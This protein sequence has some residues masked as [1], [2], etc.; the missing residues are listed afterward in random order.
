MNRQQKK[1]Y[2]SASLICANFLDLEKDIRALEK[3]KID[4]LHIDVMD[5]IFVPRYGIFP[6][7]ITQVKKISSIPMDVHMMVVDP[8]KYL[9]T[10]LD[11]DSTR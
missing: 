7:I 8:Q 5:G 4:G 11:A 9:K 3:G 10:F 6:E 2:I 1:Y